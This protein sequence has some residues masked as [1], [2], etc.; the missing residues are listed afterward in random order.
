MKI[1]ITFV[2]CGLAPAMDPH[3]GTVLAA[4]AMLAALVMLAVL[5]VLAALVMLAVLAVLAAVGW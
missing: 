3:S 4:V 5:A 1:H 2:M